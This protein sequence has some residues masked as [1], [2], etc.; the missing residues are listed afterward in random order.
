MGR[1]LVG[2]PASDPAARPVRCTIE[3][4]R[5][6]RLVEINSHH[7]FPLMSQHHDSFI[8][9]CRRLEEAAAQLKAITDIVSDEARRMA[10]AAERF[11]QRRKSPA[12]R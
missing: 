7:H 11:A 6:H 9:R 12:R 5:Q 2:F 1:V 10:A 4:E 3:P 8:E